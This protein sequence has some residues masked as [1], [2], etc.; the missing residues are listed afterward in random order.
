MIVDHR[1]ISYWDVSFHLA[2]LQLHLAIAVDNCRSIE[3]TV[4]KVIGWARVVAILQI[5]ANGLIKVH[6]NFKGWMERNPNPAMGE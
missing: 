2:D 6:A 1:I 5:T 3:T 4:E